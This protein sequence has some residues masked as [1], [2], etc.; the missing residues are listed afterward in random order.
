[1]PQHKIEQPSILIVDDEPQ[2]TTALADVLEDRYKVIT[3]TSPEAALNIL[4]SDKRISVIISDQRMPGMT[5]DE[6]FARAR[7]LSTATRVLITAYA[8]ISAVIDAVNQ[9]KIFAYVKKPWQRDD[10]ILTV[11][12]AADIAT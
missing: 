6:L 4:E 11:H 12:R 8:D 10:I 7:K 3:K 9:G 1:M 5:G 2:V